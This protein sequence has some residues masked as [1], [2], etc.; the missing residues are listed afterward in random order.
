MAFQ[1]TMLNN[2]LVPV[3]M[4][5]TVNFTLGAPQGIAGQEARAFSAS[6]AATAAAG[7]KSMG[8]R[9]FGSSGT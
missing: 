3:I 8:R 1:P 2:E 9:R 5:V 6:A 4:T 7:R